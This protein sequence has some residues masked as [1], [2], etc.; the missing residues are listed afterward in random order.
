MPTRERP[1]EGLHAE[2]FAPTGGFIFGVSVFGD[3]FG[4]DTFR[5]GISKFGDLFENDFNS[6]QW[7][8]YIN[9]ATQI[10]YDR[11]SVSDGAS[12]TAQVGLMRMTL[13]NA[14][15]PMTDYKIRAGRKVRLKYNDETLFSGTL[16]KAPGR[17]IRSKTTYT[18]YFTI[19]VAD[20]VKTLA[21]LRAYGAGGLSEP[22]EKFED[23][24]A[25]LLDT[26][27]GPVE[28]PT[29]DAY[30]S[31]R[32]GAT[33]YEGSLAAHLDLAVILARIP[34]ILRVCFSPSSHR[35]TSC[36]VSS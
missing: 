12:T 9:D 35:L 14:G 18:R 25:R 36:K 33:V 27:D 8:D 28:L 15:N 19:Q 17:I 16:T 11:G 10:T 4:G 30:P 24:I 34:V 26:Y 7:V 29:G 22:Y 13:R 1:I 20:R 3:T 2:I 21:G 32:L 6:N 31:I 5:F 23:R